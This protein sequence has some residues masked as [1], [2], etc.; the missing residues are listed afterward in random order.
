MPKVADDEEVEK[1]SEPGVA[2]SS[3]RARCTPLSTPTRLMLTTAITSSQSM[4][5]NG[6]PR[7][8]PALLNNRSSLPLVACEKA[9]T[10]W[11]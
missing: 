10:A 9:A 8:M 2:L 11:R 7:P 4:S 6:P 3:G 1:H 5:S